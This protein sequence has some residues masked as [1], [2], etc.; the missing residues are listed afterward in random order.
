MGSLIEHWEVPGQ[1][2]AAVC[3][4]HVPNVT[5]GLGCILQLPRE[6]RTRTR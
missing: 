4:Q 1:T 3:D 5:L 6:L 2:K